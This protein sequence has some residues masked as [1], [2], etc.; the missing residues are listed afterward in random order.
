MATTESPVQD[1]IL[2][3]SSTVCAADGFVPS[4]NVLS[5]LPLPE[6]LVLKEFAERC[7]IRAAQRT[8]NGDF[9]HVFSNGRAEAPH[10]AEFTSLPGPRVRALQAHSNVLMIT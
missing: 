5:Q 10:A 3:P 2:A 9:S 8:L 6:V 1:R 4:S 7:P